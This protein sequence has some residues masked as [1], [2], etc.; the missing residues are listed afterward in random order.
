MKSSVLS[1]SPFLSFFVIGFLLFIRIPSSLSNNDLFSDCSN[2]FLCG[3]ISADFPFWGTGRPSACGIHE[4]ELQCE[5]D[6]TKMI[7]N[8]VRYRVLDINTDRQ[9]LRIAREDYLVG[10]CPPQFVNSTFDPMV[11]ETVTGTKAPGA[12]YGSV[13]VPAPIIA[14]PLILKVPAL[15]EELKNGFEVRWK[16][17]SRA[18][19]E[20]LW[21]G[22]VCGYDITSNQTTCYCPNQ[23][24]GSN[25]CL[26]PTATASSG[27]YLNSGS[28]QFDELKSLLNASQFAPL[29]FSCFVH[30]NFVF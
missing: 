9:I 6:V 30:F 27:M 15:E 22:G 5:N 21:S 23:S 10:L 19:R 2:K 7:I 16:V 8:E 29:F 24:S 20:C 18:C 12:C 11:F 3:D 28:D 25:T 26:P 1:L 13:F 17:N 4:L 14:L